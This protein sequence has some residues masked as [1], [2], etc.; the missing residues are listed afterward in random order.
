MH[1]LQA[2]TQQ[3]PGAQPI[4][5][6]HLAEYDE[7][8]LHLLVADLQRWAVALFDDGDSAQLS[9]LLALV[10]QGLR[11]GDEQVTNAV[12][13]SFVENSEPWNGVTRPFIQAWPADL[14]AEAE[15]QQRS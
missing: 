8:L 7:V 1:F 10:D 4:I 12:A 6:E 5:D 14:R 9:D 3:V 2:L 11:D 15:R 13:V